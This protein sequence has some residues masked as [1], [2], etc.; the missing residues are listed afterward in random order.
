MKIQPT[1]ANNPNFGVYKVTQITHYGNR[2]TG[3]IN[4]YKLDVYTAKEDGELVH[5]LYYLADKAGNWVKSKLKYYKGGSV[6]KVIR[7]EK[8]VWMD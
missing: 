4:G 8:N 1:Y 6:I 3:L 7:S 2:V 5:K